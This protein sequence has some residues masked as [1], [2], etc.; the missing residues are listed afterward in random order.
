M[1]N[2]D[3]VKKTD[4]SNFRKIA[5]GTWTT[6][7]DPSVYGTMEIRMDE[8]TRY[9]EEY[10]E[11]TGR[12]LTVSHMMAKAVAMGLKEVPKPGDSLPVTVNFERSGSIDL[13][14]EVGE[15]GQ[16]VPAP[17]MDHSG[18]GAAKP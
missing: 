4:V 9:I 13:E 12:R 17:A 16:A 11:K 14:F 2:L 8:A 10:R 3:L 6:A 15:P 18:H 7:Y 1:P 5:I